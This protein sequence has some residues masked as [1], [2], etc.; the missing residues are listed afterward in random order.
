[1]LQSLQN[2]RILKKLDILKQL[3][4][5]NAALG[6]RKFTCDTVSATRTVSSMVSWRS[7]YCWSLLSSPRYLIPQ[8]LIRSSTYSSLLI[9]YNKLDAKPVVIFYSGFDV[10]SNSQLYP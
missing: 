4:S 8:C 2:R 10:S 6:A 1:M 9:L 7:A 3:S 5:G